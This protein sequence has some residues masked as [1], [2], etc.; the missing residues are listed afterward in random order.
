LATSIEYYRRAISE[1]STFALLYPGIADSYILLGNWDFMPRSEAY[2]QAKRA[3]TEE[4]P[5]NSTI[6]F[7]PALRKFRRDGGIVGYTLYIFTSVN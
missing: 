4:L 1:D 5:A 3:A 7:A 6:R 2:S